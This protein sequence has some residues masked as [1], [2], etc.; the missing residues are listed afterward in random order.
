MWFLLISLVTTVSVYFSDKD[1]KGGILLVLRKI[2]NIGKWS[3][4]FWHERQFPF[5][6]SPV[7]SVFILLLLLWPKIAPI[8]NE[9]PEQTSE[10]RL[11]V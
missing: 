5:Q 11:T 1:L 4:E 10:H 8:F 3:A 7:T 2:K 6:T 9:T